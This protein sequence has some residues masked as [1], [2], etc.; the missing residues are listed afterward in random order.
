V[1]AGVA[2]SAVR[3]SALFGIQRRSEFSAVRNSAP[4]GIRLLAPPHTVRH[5]AENVFVKLGIHSR[6]AVS[7]HIEQ[8][9]AE[10]R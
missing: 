10:P 5:H 1:R 7:E 2:A 8:W 9:N 4:F 3:D 6:R